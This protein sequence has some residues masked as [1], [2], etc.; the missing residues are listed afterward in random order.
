MNVHLITIGAKAAPDQTALPYAEENAAS[1]ATLFTSG[2]GFV[3]PANV[4]LLLGSKATKDALDSAIRSIPAGAFLIVYA[5]LH[6]GRGGLALADG[7]F[8][9]HDHL[10]RN[11]VAS[12]ARGVLL[13]LDSCYAGLIIGGLGG[14]PDDA[15]WLDLMFR[16]VPGFRCI[17]ASSASDTTSWSPTYHGGLF[18]W[19]LRQAT[20]ITAP[21]DLGHMAQFVSGALLYERICA[22]APPGLSPVAHG[23]LDDVPLFRANDRPIGDVKLMAFTPGCDFG[24]VAN[25]MVSGRRAMP[26]S[27]AA[28]AVDELGCALASTE[29][30]VMPTTMLDVASFSCMLDL[31]TVLRSPLA[32]QQ[33]TYGMSILVTWQIDV[34]DDLGRSL[35][36]WAID[37]DYEPAPSRLHAATRRRFCVR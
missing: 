36:S 16:S 11:L 29:W 15:E 6:G 18:T 1:I 5:M 12:G 22:V 25:L 34:V 10:R 8:Y 20:S 26:V 17:L 33:L 31:P 28:A 9:P 32:S 35:G 23:P 19:S 13:L 7:K 27:V 4:R 37:I 21:G 3:A 30:Q 2:R 14:I 24:V